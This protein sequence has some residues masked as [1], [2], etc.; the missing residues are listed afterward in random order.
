V[1][2]EESHEGDVSG[3]DLP[4]VDV[5]VDSAFAGGVKGIAVVVGGGVDG[6]RERVVG[7]GGREEFDFSHCLGKTLFEES[8]GLLE[9]VECADD[10][11]PL[12]S[13]RVRKVGGKA[14]Q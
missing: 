3:E 11:N 9:A 5:H 8:I 4:V 14:H 1:G 10:F 2:L 13:E 12:S 6:C 7:V